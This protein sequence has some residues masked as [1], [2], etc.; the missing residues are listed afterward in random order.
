[1]P[2]LASSNQINRTQRRI[3]SSRWIGRFVSKRRNTAAAHKRDGLEGE[4]STSISRAAFRC[5]RITGKPWLGIH[6]TRRNVNGCFYPLLPST[7]DYIIAARDYGFTEHLPGRRP[8]SSSYWEGSVVKT[9]LGTFISYAFTNFLPVFRIISER[10]WITVTPGKNCETSDR[11]RKAQ[12][13]LT[14]VSKALQ[15]FSNFPAVK[16]VPTS[17]GSFLVASG[18]KLATESFVSL[19]NRKHRFFCLTVSKTPLPFFRRVY[20]IF[21]YFILPTVFLEFPGIPAFQANFKSFVAIYFSEILFQ[22]S[23]KFFFRFMLSSLCGN[24]FLR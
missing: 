2:L 13:C 24:L 5:S 1:M 6:R 20:E 17:L 7:M 21:F 18:K 9:I 8:I 15:G 4:A 16:T 23:W 11:K 12:R 3:V 19:A 14:N 10:R 22:V